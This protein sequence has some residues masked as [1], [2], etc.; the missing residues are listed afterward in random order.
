M[1]RVA[2]AFDLPCPSGLRSGPGTL[3]VRP[4]SISIG[5]GPHG[6]TGTVR[7]VTLLG[8]RGARPSAR[9][10]V[11]LARKGP[12]GNVI[13]VVHV[14]D[15]DGAGHVTSRSRPFVVM[16]EGADVDLGPID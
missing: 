2:D 7:A 5:G 14:L 9:L 8:A 11:R 4:D 16:N 12:M 1:L 6:A 15:H 10:G 3:V 13:G